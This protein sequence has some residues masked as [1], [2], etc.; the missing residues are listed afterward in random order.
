MVETNRQTTL[1]EGFQR[2]LSFIEGGEVNS[3]LYKLS[4]LMVCA[5]VIEEAE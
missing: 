2:E 4:V 5:E 3:G 1:M